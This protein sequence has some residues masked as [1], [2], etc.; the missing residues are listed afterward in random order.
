MRLHPTALLAQQLPPIGKYSG[1]DQTEEGET[2]KDWMEQFEMVASVCHWDVKTKLVNLTTWLRGQAYAFYRSCTAR[3][4]GEYDT[5]VAELTRR[6]TPVRLQAV[7]SNLF[8][9][10]KQ[11][12]RET[13]D[14]YAQDLRRLFNR[15]YPRAQQGTKETEEMGR[16]ILASQFVTGLHSDIKRKVAG[17]EGAFGQLLAKA[18]FEE[19]KL[20]DLT[21][22]L[23]A[24]PKK[25]YSAPP[26]SKNPPR[27][28]STP[29]EQSPG[30]PGLRCYHCHGSGHFAKN[31]PMRGR[32]APTESRGRNT[33]AGGR[34]APKK[35]ATIV[36][37]DDVD[38]ESELECKRKRV[39][40]L[41]R[42]LQ[43]AEVDESVSEV[44]A[45]MRVLK[46][47]ER[48]DESTLGPTLATEVLFEGVPVCALLDTGS[49]VTIVSL[50]F[51]LKA[52]AQQRTKDQ[53]PAEWEEAVKLRLSPP[54]L[55]L[56]NYGGDELSIVRQLTAVI[57]REDHSCEAT[58]LVQKNAPLDL[59]L[60]TDLQAQLG[61][62]FLKTE[63]DGTAIDLL[64]K[65]RWEVTPTEQQ[66]DD[67][68]PTELPEQTAVVRLVTAVRLPARHVKCVR[69]RVDDFHE[70]GSAFFES[71]GEL[72]REKGLVLEDAVIEP[73]ARHCV[74]LMVHNNSLQ[75][76]HLDEGE[77]LGSL[78]AATVMPMPNA[79]EESPPLQEAV[80]R[81]LRPTD[82][83]PDEPEL[84]RTRCL[85]D[86]LNLG[87]SA[88]T[89]EQQEQVKDI[90]LE[91]S[92]LFALDPSELGSTDIVQHTIDTGDSKPIHQQA[93]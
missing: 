84:E 79:E 18:R 52:L 76:V 20:R 93:S 62:L 40:E 12:P 70:P 5:L 51:L 3:Q 29:G 38:K 47:R 27:E 22:E 85:L 90:L 72:L 17:M 39:A 28:K 11:K 7:Q 69:A 8:H 48:E 13:V 45:T 16:S 67:G 21:D 49:P 57:S 2:F 10:R 81:A 15:A 88:L 77:V 42:A 31:C 65:E 30:K 50:S 59:L 9:E 56:Q 26:P 64:G 86:V 23:K 87:R 92:D 1:E 83:Y 41:R 91:S 60:G 33:G 46:T 32:G 68:L 14:A 82:P 54:T 61:F 53:T 37:S 78:Q 43:E 25:P 4:R 74:T 80:V 44:V 58:V 34:D 63:T 24:I 6:F 55:T 66:R 19:A 36:V 75:P 73:D 35:V 71:E 89:E